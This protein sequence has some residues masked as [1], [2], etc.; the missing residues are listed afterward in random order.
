MYKRQVLLT[1]SFLMLKPRQRL[2]VWEQTTT[3]PY[4]AFVRLPSR[5]L[6]KVG[7]NCYF[8]IFKVFFCFLLMQT[9]MLYSMVNLTP[10][11]VYWSRWTV[12][13]PVNTVI[14][15]FNFYGNKRNQSILWLHT[16]PKDYGKMRNKNLVEGWKYLANILHSLTYTNNIPGR[17]P[18]KQFYKPEISPSHGKLHIGLRIVCVCVCCLLYTSRCV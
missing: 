8:L 3:V 6:C 12:L 18:E 10:T 1:C 9:Y 7:I 16:P 13:F 15:T 11:I 4:F 14:K 5:I 2:L 17:N